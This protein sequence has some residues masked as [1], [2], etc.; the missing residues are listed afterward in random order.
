MKVGVK[1]DSV[2]DKGTPVECEGPQESGRVPDRP[3]ASGEPSGITAGASPVVPNV[4][5]PAAKSELPSPEAVERLYV[6]YREPFVRFAASL[7]CRERQT[8]LDH[9]N[10]SFMAFQ[11]NIAS[12]RLTNLNCSLK[13]Y[14]FAVGR[15]KILRSHRDASPMVPVDFRGEL[16]ERLAEEEPDSGR[17]HSELA[18]QAVDALREPCSTVLRLYYWEQLGME[19]IARRMKYRNGQV[20]KNRKHLCMGLLRES[21]LKLFRLHGMD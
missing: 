1:P 15:N 21:L 4:P 18:R 20:A 3:M 6:Q 14:I 7:G 8:A 19:E 12:G 9:Y 2:P 13:T 16:F 17:L 5:S 10:D 11:E